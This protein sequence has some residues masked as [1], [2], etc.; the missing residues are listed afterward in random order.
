MCLFRRFN[1]QEQMQLEVQGQYPFKFTLHE[2]ASLSTL[3]QSLQ[4]WTKSPKI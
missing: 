4:A 2:L 1:E 3:D